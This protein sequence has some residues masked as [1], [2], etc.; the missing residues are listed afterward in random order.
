MELTLK[1]IGIIKDSTIKL[2]G[3]TVITGPNNSGKSTAGKAL[4]ALI[5]CG[6]NVSEKRE[7]ELSLLFS[8][9]LFNITRTLNLNTILRDIDINLLT[10]KEKELFD[11][12]E[13][14]GFRSL[15]Y[16]DIETKF[17]ELKDFLDSLCVDK[18]I[19]IA[20]KPK[21]E[22]TKRFKSYLANFD[23]EVKNA[24]KSLSRLD[25][26]MDDPSYDKFI[27]NGLLNLLNEEFKGQIYP[28]KSTIKEKEERRSKIVL[29]RNEII[30][31]EAT[32]INNEKVANTNNIYRTAL[33]Q[34]VYYIDDPYEIDK[35]S[36]NDDR[37]MLFRGVEFNYAH[38]KKL[39]TALIARNITPIEQAI[40]DE[41]YEKIIEKIQ[42]IVPG[43]MVEKNGIYYY[44]EDETPPL[45]IENLA[46]GSKMFS[47]IKSLMSKG[48]ITLNTMLILDEPEAHLHPEWQNL[49][50]QFIIELIKEVGVTVLLTTH[51]PNFLM[52]LEKF[53]QVSGIEEKTNF[54]HVKHLEDGYMVH[55]EHINGRLSEAYSSFAKPLIE[56]QKKD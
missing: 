40:A 10:D 26:F 56:L 8:R 1:N 55:Y 44:V 15:N 18:I 4:Y 34:D 36:I 25:N 48:K 17:F 33:Y 53:S 37:I 24:R 28:I 23:D 45:R 49:F 3:L 2:D 14:N 19:A 7:K 6:C 21:S 38:A 41:E 16:T 51:S 22:W 29:T 20:K 43:N 13:I 47:I 27:R 46:T 30:G 52:A 32:I 35:L 54:Y 39:E 9:I 42:Q 50:A 11:L 5:E 31:C 12:F